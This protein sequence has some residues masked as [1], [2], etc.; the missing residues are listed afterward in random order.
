MA[1]GSWLPTLGVV[2]AAVLVLA[3]GVPTVAGG[4]PAVQYATTDGAGT[5][6]TADATIELTRQ[7]HLT[8]D[9]P[10][11]IA[12]TLAYAIPSNVVSL[13]AELP[14]AAAVTGT[15]GFDRVDGTEYEWDGQTANPRIRFRITANQTFTATG[16][17]GGDG[18]YL[19]V[20][21][22]PWALV[23][24]PRSAT[25]W[26]WTDGGTVELSR[27]TTT[28]G[29][30]AVGSDLAFLGEHTEHTRTAHGQTFR[31]IV[32]AE[33]DLAE[34]P[35][36]ILDSMAA[37]S[38]TLRVGDRDEVVLLVAAP[39]STVRW[40]VRG[41]QIGDTDIW[42]RDAERLDTADNVWLHEYVHTRQ[43]Y[44]AGDDARWFTEA[45]A[46]YYA[47]LLSLE[48]ERIGF[49]AFRDRLSLGTRSPDSDAVLAEPGTWDSV[50]PY[51][52]GALVA[53]EL[54]RQVRTA[55][56]RGRSLQDVLARM[57]GEAEPV[58]G[59]QLQ[60]WLGEAGGDD[61]GAAAEQYTTTSA[62]PTTW[63]RTA[64]ATAFGATPARISSALPGAEAPAGYRVSGPFRNGSLGTD[65]PPRLVVGETLAVDVVTSNT[66]GT[67]GEFDVRLLV[68]GTPIGRESG[69]LPAGESVTLTFA[70]QFEAPGDYT[71]AIGDQRTTV[72]VRSP[73]TPR[74]ADLSISRLG[75]AEDNVERV[76]VTATV[77][78][79]HE[80]P[81][82]ADLTL[83]VDGDPVETREVTLAPKG[84]D[85]VDF[86]ELRLEPG[87][88]TLSVDG[89]TVT[90]SVDGETVTVTVESPSLSIRGD[91]FGVI[92]AVVALF[93]LGLLFGRRR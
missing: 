45:S 25:S 32:P 57:N 77:A 1:R 31:L 16:P 67:I 5:A 83:V 59:A 75:P 66:G 4:P 79:D 34:P 27:H 84:R 18:D 41:F 22:G 87:E 19:F 49:E 61:V 23:S 6:E 28:D 2:I 85:E 91:G 53:G 70:H 44:D 65:R 74:V 20:D 92:A 3:S 42:V 30:G 93:A 82:A 71:L 11:E 33:A 38:D 88:H 58:T 7:L 68:D 47:A 14:A 37:A 39:T 80:R 69:T 13:T 54:D 8:P 90:L 64:H 60:T 52:K 26:G 55:S 62:A 29:P 89:E 10:G 72:E 76:A 12:V 24:V 78:N 9:R 15:R 81:A 21:V 73:A 86:A 35:D 17:I 50:A 56:E 40:G 43:G 63:N 48:Q 36:R 46:S 51:T